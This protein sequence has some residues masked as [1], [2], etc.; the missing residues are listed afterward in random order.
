LL[1]NVLRYSDW[2]C[3]LNENPVDSAVNNPTAIVRE[4]MNFAIPYI[5]SK[6][7]VFPHWFS[8]LHNIKKKTR[9]F[10]RYKK[11]KSIHN[12]SV[13]S[14]YRRLVKT[15]IKTDRFRWLNIYRW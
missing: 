9:H 3:V 10:R 1:Y 7:S 13:F 8:N 5:K 4:A 12:Y 11:S 6:N 15:T 2:S 14:Y